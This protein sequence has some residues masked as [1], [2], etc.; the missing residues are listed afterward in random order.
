MSILWKRINEA[1]QASPRFYDN[2]MN[3]KVLLYCLVVMTMM[4]AS[5]SRYAQTRTDL[6]KKVAAD[7]CA[8]T[9]DELDETLGG[10]EELGI[11]VKQVEALLKNAVRR[12]R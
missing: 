4:V 10:L 12:R 9:E 1:I 5:E 3:T 7:K 6:H 2:E 11:L 8:F